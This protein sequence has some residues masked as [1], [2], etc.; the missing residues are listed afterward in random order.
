MITF[1]K[2]AADTI[3]VDGY[4][5]SR[6]SCEDLPQF[7]GFAGKLGL[8][9]W[10]SASLKETGEPL[11]DENGI[12]IALRPVCAA[13][14]VLITLQASGDGVELRVVKDREHPAPGLLPLKLD[15]KTLLIK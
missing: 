11:Y 14:D 12:P 2:F 9:V 7:K 10:F 6:P 5:F 4:D 13:I 8:E 1:G 3:I 15:P